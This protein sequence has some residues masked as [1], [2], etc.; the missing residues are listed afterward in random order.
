V[1]AV[2]SPR[3]EWF[4]ARAMSACALNALARRNPR[5]GDA[6]VDIA[7]RHDNHP[8]R[9]RIRSSGVAKRRD[10]S[11]SRIR[12]REIHLVA[13]SRGTG[14]RYSRYLGGQLRFLR[15]I[16][17]KFFAAVSRERTLTAS[18]VCVCMQ[19][20]SARTRISSTGSRLERQERRGSSDTSP[21]TSKKPCP[22]FQARVEMSGGGRMNTLSLPAMW[23]RS[24]APMDNSSART[25]TARC[26][27][28]L[29]RTIVAAQR[30]LWSRL[31]SHPRDCGSTKPICGS[32]SASMEV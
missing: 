16:Y 5:D 12:K 27:S 21:V 26:S 13:R 10:Y 22:T 31:R 23:R 24:V 3:P 19:L 9:F 14:R 7:A 30:R 4:P 18:G 20:A 8:C 11:R 32:L 1:G 17:E 15:C 28:R 6:R 29:H 25:R 2:E